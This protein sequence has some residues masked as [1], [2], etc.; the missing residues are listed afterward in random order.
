MLIVKPVNEPTLV[1]FGC[2]FVYTVPDTN[3]LLTCPETLAPATLLAVAAYVTSP[4][5]LAPATALA[6]VAKLTAP[7]TLAPVNE[8]NPLPLPV[9]IPAPVFNVPATL[10]P[11]PVITIM[12]L[13]TAVKFMLPFTAGIFTLLLPLACGPSKLPPVILAV[14]VKLD[15]VPTLV[16]LG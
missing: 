7:V 16:M 5:T 11:V 10:T 4:L 8:L 9:I 12:V 13:P 3:A 1:M 6:V 15:N 2:A 14:T